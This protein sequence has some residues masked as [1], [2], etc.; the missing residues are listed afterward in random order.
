M[1][2]TKLNTSRENLVYLGCGASRNVYALADNPELVIKKPIPERFDDGLAQNRAEMEAYGKISEAGLDC[3]AKSYCIL[4]NGSLVAERCDRVTSQKLSMM[5]GGI[6]RRLGFTGNQFRPKTVDYLQSFAW[7]V[8]RTLANFIA[9][10]KESDKDETAKLSEKVVRF[11]KKCDA[12]KIPGHDCTNFLYAAFVDDIP[13][14]KPFRDILLYAMDNPNGLVVED[15]WNETQWGM[16]QD[17][18]LKVIDYGYDK[19][20]QN[21]E[22][23]QNNLRWNVVR[24]GPRNKKR[25]S[26]ILKDEKS[27]MYFL[28]TDRQCQIMSCGSWSS[29]ANK[30]IYTTPEKCREMFS[31]ARANVPSTE[32]FRLSLKERH[33]V[34]L[35][36]L[37]DERRVAFY[38]LDEISTVPKTGLV[39]VMLWMFGDG[40][41]RRWYSPEV[42]IKSV[43]KYEDAVQQLS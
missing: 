19:S 26:R 11:F 12:F 23:Y 20:V 33:K 1:D 41:V 13:Q 32:I 37:V 17:G 22:T 10:V 8:T 34:L 38:T 35:E 39:P 18:K 7:D 16:T 4:P 9:A 30:V 36:R 42:P 27:N 2:Y 24:E 21:R 6:F 31:V 29:W 25:I 43:E 3:F 40:I 5:L 28:T 14:L 15:L